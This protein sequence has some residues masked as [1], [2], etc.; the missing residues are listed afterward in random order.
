MNV[1]KKRL[2][3][4]QREDYKAEMHPTDSKAVTITAMLVHRALKPS[5]RTS[6]SLAALPVFFVLEI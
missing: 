2:N 1:E 5:L 3:A 4:S 6:V